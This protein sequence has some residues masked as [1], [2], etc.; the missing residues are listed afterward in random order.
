MINTAPTEVTRN[1]RPFLHGPEAAAMNDALQAGQYGHSSRVEEFEHAVADY[2]GVPDMVAVASGTAALQLALLAAGTG[3]GDEVIVPSQT[4]CASVHAILATG[5]RPR[6]IEIN[7]H[8]LCID[9]DQ[10]R[11]AITPATRAVL[12]VL[13]GGRAVDLSALHDTL[14]SQGISVVQ[15]AAHAFGSRSGTTLVG[16]QPGVLTCFSFGP[17]KNLTCGQGGGIIPRTTAEADALRGLRSLGITQSQQERAAAT[18]YSVHG[19][20][21]RATMS[22]LN[23]AI[24][25]VQLQHFATVAAKRKALWT[26]YATRLKPLTGV[27]LVDVD[28]EHT[29]PFNC[30]VHIPDRDRVFRELR[31]RGIG[32]GVHY[33]PNHTQPAFQAW[34]R[35]LPV[36]EE[37]GRHLMSLPFHPAMSDDDVRHVVSVLAHAL[38]QE[39]ACGAC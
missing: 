19:F 30:V 25:L 9:E 16:A 6:F 17:I 38:P 34:N 12:P 3:P 29:V 13:Y 10:V 24:G 33:P 27:A 32:A 5:A 23:A 28:V 2:L 39:D 37:S 21:L 4:F 26:S 14:E 7:P 22:D 15:D 1:A 35:P 31:R 36:T 11:A 20:G 18:T 8:T